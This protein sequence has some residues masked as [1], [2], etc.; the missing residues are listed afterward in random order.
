MRRYTEAELLEFERQPWR[1]GELTEY[2]RREIGT[3]EIPQFRPF[4]NT[5]ERA[6]MRHQRKLIYKQTDP[7][8]L[9]KLE[10]IA[11]TQRSWKL[12]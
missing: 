1:I 2:I 11:R 3:V 12:L 6:I 7:E 10:K 4:P 5:Q 8:V 9:K